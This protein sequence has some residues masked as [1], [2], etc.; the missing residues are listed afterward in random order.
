MPPVDSSPDNPSRPV[1]SDSAYRRDAIPDQP[2]PEKATRFS[3]IVEGAG[4]IERLPWG[5]YAHLDISVYPETARIHQERMNGNGKEHIAGPAWTHEY[6]PAEFIKSRW[7][8]L[9][10][11]AG[12]LADYGVLKFLG[13]ILALSIPL[14]A[15]GRGW[16][17]AFLGF[18]YVAPVL[19]SLHVFFRYPFTWLLESYPHLIVKDLGCGFFRTTGMIKFRT[20]REETFEAPFV[21]FDPYIEFH[22]NPKG[23]VT[24]KL[25]LCHRYKGWDTTVAQVAQV[26]KVELYAFWDELQRYMDVSQPLPDIPALEKFRPLDPTTAEYD[27]AGRRGRPADYWATLALE[28]WENEG[29]PAHLEKIK[30]SPLNSDNNRSTLG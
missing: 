26:N 29:Y 19:L 20:W 27:A 9:L 28:W 7:Q 11:L 23:P 13:A 10:M 18:M 3:K 8:L 4:F 16:N 2:A 14:A 24:Y 30:S 6:Q 1:Y 25:V 17:D 5:D 15:I 22:V 12:A 21:E